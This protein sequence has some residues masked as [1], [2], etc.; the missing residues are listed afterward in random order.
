ML[1]NPAM[2]FL[3][4]GGLLYFLA[5][6]RENF[7]LHAAM[8]LGGAALL[9]LS[10]A[11]GL[12]P[13]RW[14]VKIP[15]PRQCRAHRQHVLLRAHRDRDHPRGRRFPPRIERLGT[16]AGRGDL[17]IA[18][19]LLFA[20]V[21]G[22]VAFTQAVHRSVFGSGTTFTFMSPGEALP[23]KPFIWAYLAHRTRDLGRRRGDAPPSPRARQLFSGHVFF[24]SS[25]VRSRSS[26]ATA[27]TPT[28]VSKP[29]LIEPDP[30][31]RSPRAAPSRSIS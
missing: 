18:G 24:C 23:V 15:V 5:T 9:P 3:L 2:N 25:R 17:V 27:F 29:S 16:P 7:S 10:L 20:L 26:G 1:F 6:L 8:A 19:L 4:L 28:P 30:A 11:F 14:I 21:F 31:R 22:Y 12:I 13:A